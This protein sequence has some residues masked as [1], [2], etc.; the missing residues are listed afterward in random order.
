MFQIASP[1]LTRP[2]GGVWRGLTTGRVLVLPHTRHVRAPHPPRARL[3][4]LS[5]SRCAPLGVRGDPCGARGVC[6][7]GGGGA[8]WCGGGMVWYYW[9]REP[10]GPRALCPHLHRQ[11]GTSRRPPRVVAP[12]PALSLSCLHAIPPLVP[13]LHHPLEDRCANHRRGMSA[14]GPPVVALLPSVHVSY[15]ACAL[16]CCS[17]LRFTVLHRPLA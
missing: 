4:K 5:D 9:R 6:I 2:R 17:A 15:S 3:C 13:P 12:R 8:V 14:F 7:K 11:R 10:V 1:T 16:S